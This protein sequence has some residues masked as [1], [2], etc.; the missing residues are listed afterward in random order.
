M[1]KPVLWVDQYGQHVWAR[2]VKELRAKS[3][4]GRIS[5]MYV[6][7]KDGSASRHVGYVVGGRWF[8]GFIPMQRP[9]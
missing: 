1:N 9:A 5:K 2:T 3:G 6:D 8:T 7:A 4:G